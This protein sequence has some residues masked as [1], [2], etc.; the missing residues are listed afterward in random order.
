MSSDLRDDDYLWDPRAPVD[1]EVERLERLLAPLAH[2]PGR[3]VPSNLPAR[4]RPALRAW[5]WVGA[6]AATVL[7]VLWVTGRAP[8]TV[9]P[10]PASGPELV[11][12]EPRQQL[13][14]SAWLET[15]AEER[16]LRLGTVGQVTLGA[17]SRL[18][19]RRLSAEETRLYLERG[20]LEALVSADAQPRFFQ[21]DTPATRCV[22][23]GCRYTLV[24]DERGDALVEVETG[25]VAFENDGRA[26]LVPRGASCRATRAAGAGTPRFLDAAAHLVEALDGFDAAAGER[27]ERR[28]ALAAEALRAALSLRDAL[29]V[30]HLLQDPDAEIAALAHLRLAELTEAPAAARAT[31]GSAPDATARAAW[32]ETLE[33]SWW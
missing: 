18:E 27:S 4:R 23:L 14:E 31:L 9:V 20:R 17:G 11:A 3:S 5:A 29:P 6:L 12:L 15:G 26:V 7:A 21:V 10:P 8:D 22:D 30:W 32:R 24:V 2:V 1:P 13:A 19:V 16:E 28:R 25:R 33:P